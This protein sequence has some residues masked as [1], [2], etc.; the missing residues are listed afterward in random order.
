MFE[1]D[2]KENKNYKAHGNKT[3]D[4]LE[5]HKKTLRKEAFGNHPDPAKRRQF[6]ECLKAINDLKKREKLKL[7]NKT[8]IFQE[9]QFNKNRWKFSKKIVSGT[10][11]CEEKNPTFDK[12]TADHF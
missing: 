8:A 3:I 4:Q 7:Q 9:K 2:A 1:D 5:A 6:H 12:H 10:F 11:G